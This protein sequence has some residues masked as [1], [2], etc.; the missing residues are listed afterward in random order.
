MQSL[1]ND[2]VDCFEEWF[3]V[4]TSIFSLKKGIISETIFPFWNP[5]VHGVANQRPKTG[6][7]YTA[8]RGTFPGNALT[9]HSILF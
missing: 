6:F 2:L 9:W 8:R 5:F 1:A 4:Q 7:A 3:F